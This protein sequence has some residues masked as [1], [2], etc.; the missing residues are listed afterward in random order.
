VYVDCFTTFW[1]EG[2]AEAAGLAHNV[3]PQA[4]ILLIG[5][6][7]ALAED[8]ARAHLPVDALAPMVSSAIST[9][10]SDFSLCAYTPRFAYISLGGGRRSAEDAVN[11]ITD[12]LTQHK[13]Q[14]FAFV[15]HGIAA[16]CAQLFGKVLDL[17]AQRTLKAAFYAL[18]NIAPG[19]LVEHS[20]L[21]AQMK[22]A[23][24]RQ[25]VF[26]DDR[27]LPLGSGSDQQLIEDYRQAVALCSKAGFPQRTDSLV[28]SICIGRPGEDLEARA[29]LAT[30]IAHHVGSII[31]WAYQPSPDEC[32]GIPLE[33][34]NGKIFPLR[35]RNNRR[36]RDYIDLLGLA[37]ILN[38]KY[39]E[40]TFD[41]LGESLIPRLL[42]ES[43][44]RRGWDPD[45]AVKGSLVLPVRPTDVRQ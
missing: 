32:I 43:F 19:D 37:A 23:G 28:G 33:D 30:V 11:E 42:R 25:I 41:F 10:A 29:Q 5:A 3:F 12:K 44:G 27:H 15:E 34:Q 35:G 7:G 6:Y 40:H 18:G 45:P 31:L 38:A 20:E 21:P 26:A 22:R 9:L 13:I 39:R 36:Y 1:W 4:K 24:F 17:L 8:H 2:A 16:E 14:H